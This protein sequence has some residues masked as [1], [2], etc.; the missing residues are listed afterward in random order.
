MNF[1]DIIDEYALECKRITKKKRKIFH[2][3]NSTFTT[4]VIEVLFWL[5]LIMCVLFCVFTGLNKTMASF[6][7]IVIMLIL[8]LFIVVLTKTPSQKKR[9][10]EYN[11]FV[12]DN[13]LEVLKE[14]LNRRDISFESRNDINT[15][16]DGFSFKLECLKNHKSRFRLY[17]FVPFTFLN[18]FVTPVFI[19]YIK[20]FSPDNS[21]NML[22]RYFV[23]YVFLFIMLAVFISIAE[24]RIWR[25]NSEI[26]KQ[27]EN[28]IED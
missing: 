22:T 11:C 9:A 16:I 19:D 3:E 13:R 4:Y 18:F 25:Y 26:L 1:D 10:K 21:L 15:L 5:M 24:T 23:L 14:V 8:L 2:E 27:Y 28:I 7:C 12:S 17:F 20:V 6:I